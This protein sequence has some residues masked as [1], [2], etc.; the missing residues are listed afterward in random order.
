MLGIVG[1]LISGGA[2]AVATGFGAI[3]IDPSHDFTPSMGG[4]THLLELMGITALVSGIISLAKFLQTHPVP[5]AAKSLAVAAD[6]NAQ[7]GAAIADAQ[8]AVLEPPKGG[9]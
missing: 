4:T 9:N 7:A 5:D 1:A 8:K 6:A 3:I 2:G